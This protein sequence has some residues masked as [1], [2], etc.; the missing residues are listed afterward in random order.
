[1]AQAAMII[2]LN[3]M[4][5]KSL[6]YSISDFKTYQYQ[7]SNRRYILYKWLSCVAGKYVKLKKM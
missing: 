2:E 5:N 4:A 7:T 1:M 6:G 3:K